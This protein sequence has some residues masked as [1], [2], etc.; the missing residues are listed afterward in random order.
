MII[1]SNF[2]DYYDVVQREGQD[3][4]LIYFR[5]PKE[6][7]AEKCPVQSRLIGDYDEKWRRNDGPQCQSYIVGFCGKIY[8]ILK[9]EVLSAEPVFCINIEDID[10]FADKY[11]DKHAI[12]KYYKGVAKHRWQR[13][14]S[15]YQPTRNYY[16]KYFEEIA[17]EQNRYQSLFF[18]DRCPTFVCTTDTRMYNP[19][20][21][22]GAY[23]SK[24]RI[25]TWNAPLKDIEFYRII[26]PYTAFQEI[27][28]FLSGLASPEKVIPEIDDKTMRDIKGFDKWSFRKEPTKKK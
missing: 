15:H 24:I 22:G 12:K 4:D 1:R 18:E 27:N 10:A 7:E 8:P 11:L 14:F 16:I 2:H 25:L 9:M 21:G 26:D 5:F 3:Y 23:R 19:P 28:M 20:N 17:E 13:N 6:L